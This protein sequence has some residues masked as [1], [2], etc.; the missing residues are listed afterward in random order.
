LY[1]QKFFVF[2]QNVNKAT[3]PMS[4]QFFNAF[5]PCIN[6][7]S[8]QQCMTEMFWKLHSR[9]HVLEIAL[10]MMIRICPLGLGLCETNF[11]GYPG[12]HGGVGEGAYQPLVITPSKVARLYQRGK[13]KRAVGK[14][15]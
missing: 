2:Q 13:I 12:I 7:S 9:F 11:T 15:W 5:E 4:L 3:P 1:D 8:N 6:L 10:K 14:C